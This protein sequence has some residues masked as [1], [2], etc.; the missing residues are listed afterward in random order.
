M[1]S[2]KVTSGWRFPLVVALGANGSVAGALAWML[3]P[4]AEFSR[5]LAVARTGSS[6]ETYAF[7][8]HGKLISQS[9]FDDQLRRLGLIENREESTSALTLV[10]RDPGRRLAEGPSVNPTGGESLM[11]SVAA[12]VA[13]GSGVQT[14]AFRDYRG[15]DVVGAWRWLESKGFG[16]ATQ[17][18]AAEAFA[19][20]RMLRQWFALL[21]A[22]LGLCTL[23]MLL[24]AQRNRIW[25]SR[26]NEASLKAK[27]LG[28]YDLIE[29]I[30]EGG[31]GVVYKARHALLRRETAVKLLLPDRANERALR[32]FEQE[33]RLTCR[34]THPN[35][36]Q[37]FD[38]GH[39][40]EG[41]FYYAME[42]LK[43]LNLAELLRIAGPLPESRVIHILRQ[44]CDS[45]HEAHQ[46]GLIHRDIKLENILVVQRA[47]LADSVKVL[48]F[49]LVMELRDPEESTAPTAA[50]RLVGTPRY[51]APETIENPDRAD[52][53]SDLYA[54]G[55]VSYCL[56]TGQHVFEGTSVTTLVERHVKDPPSPRARWRD[57]V[58]VQCSSRRRCDVSR[59]TLDSVRS[60]PANFRP[61][62]SEAR[63]REAGL[64]KWL[65]RGGARRIAWLRPLAKSSHTKK[66]RN[67][68]RPCL[69]I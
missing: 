10:L 68:P 41:I 8:G 4:Q 49:G 5:I 47:G 56:M 46:A 13:G 26:F 9:R 6:G 66:W 11:A 40:P 43:G 28:Q 65:K 58:F 35:T 38:Y 32:R 22:L 60:R 20:Q 63:M 53:R 7:D 57:G 45:L 52:P 39:T 29:K 44:I 24:I 2:E 3:R 42:Y 33:V 23:G 18:D 30:G 50:R 48:D 61:P 54:L 1:S 14:A 67:W 27:Q 37:I 17:I 64:R 16:V 34:L 15:V 36:I 69:S 19:T 59:K 31:M 12:A 51:M 62:L 25:K 21:L 55:V